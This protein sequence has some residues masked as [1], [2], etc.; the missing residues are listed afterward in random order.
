MAQLQLETEEI[1]ILF[2]DLFHK[3]KASFLK[4]EEQNEIFF[5][6]L[7]DAA[8]QLFDFKDECID[9]LES[10][11]RKLLSKIFRLQSY[12][13]FDLLLSIIKA[14]GTMEDKDEAERYK[15]AFKQYAERRTFESN[16]EIL[17]S[18]PEHK[19]V[20]FM[21]DKGQFPF[22]LINAYT[23]KAKLCKLLDIERYKIILHEIK[24]GSIIIVFQISPKC[25]DV[26]RSIP[27]FYNKVVSL[28]EESTRSY[29]LGDEEVNL[30][31]WNVIESRTVVCPGSERIKHVSINGKAY[32]ALRYHKTFTDKQKADIGYVKYLNVFMSGKYKNLPAVKGVYYHP[33]CQ[34]QS[35]TTYYYPTIIV[36]KLKSLK[37]VLLKQEIMPVHQ[38]SLLLDISCTFLSLESDRSL[39]ITI[40]PDSVFVEEGSDEDFTARV[41]PL[42]NYSYH[43]IIKAVS[44]DFHLANCL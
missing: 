32:L 5:E 17:G 42:Y 24:H 13:N 26:F 12:V 31:C 34:S 38:I 37:D 25:I 35:I 23:F 19:T 41:C 6:D 9:L 3:F 20:M 40:Y 43:N 36:E 33:T 30:K 29:K 7:G 39:H 2:N 16:S 14:C 44:Q 11:S 15:K 28:K 27:L 22:R 18:I 21:L 1:K 10:N 4:R 8:Q